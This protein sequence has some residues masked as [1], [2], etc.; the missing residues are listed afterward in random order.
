LNF[1]KWD[2]GL[3]TYDK[4]S[5]DFLFMATKRLWMASKY[6]EMVCLLF[7]YVESTIYC[8]MTLTFPYRI[9]LWPKCTFVPYLFFIV[10]EVLNCMC[11]QVGSNGEIQIIHM[12]KVDKKYI[13]VQYVNATSLT[14]V[15]N[16]RNG[17]MTIDLFNKFLLISKLELNLQKNVEFWCSTTNMKP[18]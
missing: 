7:Q 6:I 11:K 16:E 14:L 8:N 15:E 4:A 17:D 10:W 3:K 5:W 18:N 9:R 1:I 13:L 2:F 12:L